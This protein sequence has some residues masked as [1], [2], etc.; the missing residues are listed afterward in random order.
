MLINK[1]I[2]TV[3]SMSVLSGLILV[4]NVGLFSL[5]KL[6]SFSIRFVLSLIT[7]GCKCCLKYF[8]LRIYLILFIQYYI[9]FIYEH[10]ATSISVF[11]DS[12]VISV[13]ELTLL[14]KLF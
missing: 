10:T 1:Y 8:L 4:S 6:S 5:Q 13:V 14:Q 3:N 7:G 12:I 9:I 11:S 2:F